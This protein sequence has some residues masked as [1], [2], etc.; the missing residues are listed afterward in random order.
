MNAAFLKG[1]KL[2]QLIA[3]SIQMRPN[4]GNG[5]W[6][7]ATANVVSARWEAAKRFAGTM[8]MAMRLTSQLIPIS[9]SNPPPT[10][11][12]VAA[13]WGFWGRVSAI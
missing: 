6:N 4:L 2:V 10:Q 12:S 5:V 8:T 9:V 3:R 11:I 13:G 1:N 7:G